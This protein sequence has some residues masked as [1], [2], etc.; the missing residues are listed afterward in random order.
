MPAMPSLRLA[1]RIR[2]LAGRST[3]E[4]PRHADGVAAAH[5]FAGCD[6]P[7]RVWR[8]R[9][10]LGF[11]AMLAVSAP[12]LRAQ[13]FVDIPLSRCVWHA[14]DDPAWAAPDFDDRAWQPYAK[15]EL[16]PD[17]P[18][19]WIR[20][21][22]DL[23]V[24]R[25]QAHPAIQIAG[26]AYQL[27]L[28]GQLIGASGD[29]RSGQHS[30]NLIR[31]FPVAAASVPAG[32]TAIALRATLRSLDLSPLLGA[33]AGDTQILDAE[34]AQTVI[35][36]ASREIPDAFCYGFVGIIALLL[37][38]LY[39]Y[40]RSRLEL[41]LLGLT[42]FGLSALRFN[43]LCG[44][45]FLDYPW[46]VSLFIWTVGNL[47]VL[48][49]PWFFFR[50]AGRRVPVAIWILAALSQLDLVSLPSRLLASPSVALRASN[51][52]DSWLA[53]IFLSALLLLSAAPFVAF[54]PWR[55]VP[56]RLRAL[57]V[58]CLLWGLTDMLWFTVAVVTFL[59]HV[60][61]IWTHWRTQLLE[62]RAVTTAAVLVSLLG[63][64][65]RDQRRTTEERALL[66]GE[67]QAA[68]DIQTLLAPSVLESIP[69]LRIDVAFRPMRE[70]GGD[71]YLCRALSDGCQRLLVG[72]VSGKGT[73]AAMT[74][75]LL[76]GA[77]ERRS[78]DS[79]A[80]L[81]EHLNSVLRSSRV[82]GFATCLCADVTA[83]GIVTL[84]NA[85]HLPP[86][87][88]GDELP[89]PPAL[90]L[91]LSEAA[92]EESRFVLEAG[93]TLTFLSDGVVEA[94]NSEGQL[95][96]FDRARDMSTRSPEQIAAAA[97]AF[98]Q[99]DDITVLTLT[100]APAAVLHA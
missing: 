43:E 61:D 86:Y 66:A 25:S 39:L 75:T 1:S 3:G 96:G 31:S 73:G 57:A 27:Y 76:I 50:L 74:A 48:T 21:H 34:R 85:G 23:S 15:F 38:A 95:F 84:A 81:L 89:V 62:I 7:H 100:F 5:S 94:Q 8:V 14:G 59:P 19:L 49:Q 71:F 70:V 16:R 33:D 78:S 11:L 46:R 63:L 26:L 90:P 22:V 80:S 51:L 37:T 54:F 99:K 68:R 10:A 64:L 88:R 36:S 77:A 9:V 47:L 20:C 83:E 17:V 41:L 92:Y 35:N 87:T 13:V 42:C 56:R 4:A 91:G 60:P 67:L 30:Q 72:D 44:A 58:A 52:H 18:H 97:Q 55:H 53:P 98:G 69:G 6:R 2:S 28:D 79:P 32:A 24:L 93:E 40:D 12:N 29:I 45:A 65:F 82:G